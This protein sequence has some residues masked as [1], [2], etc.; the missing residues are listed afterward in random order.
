MK[1]SLRSCWEA[2]VLFWL[3]LLIHCGEARVLTEVQAGPLYRVVDTPLS[4]S[5]NTSGFSSE[6]IPKEFQFRIKKPANPDFE[7]NIISTDDEKFSYAVYA[8]RVRAKTIT[9]THVSPNSILFE[10]QSLQKNDEGEYDCAVVNKESTYDGVYSVSTIVKVIDNSLSVSSPGPT[11]LSYNEGDDLTL[12]CQASSNTVQHT[13]LALTWYLHKDNEDNARPIISLDRDLTVSPGQG[14]DERYKAGLI[15][16][17]KMGETTYTLKMAELELSDQGRVYCQAQEWIQ[18]PDRSW[19]CIIQKDSEKTTLN[20]KAREVAPDTLSLVVRISA[21]E[22]ALQEGQELSL[23]CSVDTQNL[24]ERFF[25]VAWLRGNVELAR[26]GP[27]GILSVG[28]QYSVREK[29]GE[30][31]AARVGNRDYRL[32]L[33]P[34]R[35]EDQGEYLCR[36]WPQ[37]RDQNGAFTQGAAQDSSSQL[38]SISATESGL[39]IEMQDTVSVNEGDRLNLICKV[40]GVKGQLSV[41]WQRKSES[42]A[43]FASVSLSQDGVMEKEGDFVNR[44][45][46]AMRPAADSFTLE[47]DEVTPLDSGEYECAVSEWK[48]NSKTNSKSQTATVTVV[49]AESL[50]KLSLISRNNNVTVG[51]NVELMCRVRG[52]RMPITLTWSRQRDQPTLDNILTLYS[53]GAISWSGDQHRYQLKVQNKVNEV[54]HSLLINGASHREAGRYQCRVSVFLQNVNKKVPPSHPLAVMVHNRVSKLALTSPK[55]LTADINT[56]IEIKCSVTSERSVSSRYAVTWLFQQQAE[57]KVIVSSDRDALITFGPWMEQQHR[58]RISLRR[59]KGP[60][61]ELTIQQ[62]QISDKGSYICKV[63]EWLPDPHGDW[64][65]LSPV[66]RTTLL[67]VTE[68]ANDLRLD[69]KEQQQLVAREGDKVELKCNIISGAS[70]PSFFYKVSWLYT[71]QSSLVNITLLELDHTGLLRYPDNQALRDLQ[72]RLH[73]TRPSQSSFLLGIQRAHESDSGTYQCLVDQY[74]L[75]REGHWQQKL[76]DSAGPIMLTV[77]V[78][79]KNLSVVRNEQE[80]NVSRAFTIPCQITKQS[81]SES[82]FQVTWFWKKDSEAEQQPIFTAY[83]NSTLQDRFVMGD[84]L[85]FD[86]PLPTHFNLTLLKPRPENSGLYFCEV[87]EW[88]PS[89]SH[90]W[91]KVAVEKSG[92]STVNV[93]EEAF[94]ERQHQTITWIFVALL[95]CSLV[96]ISVLVLIICR[97]K[98]SGGKKSD[99]TLW[100]EQHPLNAKPN[101]EE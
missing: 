62:T 53:D 43:Q 15:R 85:K 49:P 11:S 10:I 81:S 40:D 99:Q 69:A 23:S 6:S 27:T 93:Y 54:I 46:R 25:S 26:I 33:Q 19:Y 90:G 51:D 59:T 79:E 67:T 72:G 22:T 5:C 12:I 98:A 63:V 3:G 29:E 36:A 91:R 83:R 32:I 55:T 73:L 95:I 17:D 84:Q 71:G 47:L 78:A 96:V 100:I 87:E 58:Q 30:L 18:D 8:Q 4:I 21:Q 1:C 60:R 80:W 74:Q 70:N 31:R 86:H 76:S 28:P 57:E 16:L 101:A 92:Y 34:V 37:D 20:V 48:S 39:T 75:D 65:Q 2:S 13:H 24:E 35:T 45:V 56:D 38:I 44:K 77:N 14:F 66:A 68:P 42:T 52:P 82:E 50:V 61:F 97:N 41:T 7:I 88:L 94:F 9:L 64:Y 89:L